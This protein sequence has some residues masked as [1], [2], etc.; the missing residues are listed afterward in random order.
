MT[1]FL[2]PRIRMRDALR[3]LIDETPVGWERPS[4]FVLRNRLLDRTGSDAR[5]LAELLLEALRRG[6]GDRL[7]SGRL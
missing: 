3:E 4:L 7:P 1:S 2:D 5:P 6:W